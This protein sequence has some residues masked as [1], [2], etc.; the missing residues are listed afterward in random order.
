MEQQTA[1][2][3]CSCQ[4]RTLLLIIAKIELANSILSNWSRSHVCHSLQCWA[5]AQM[6]QQTADAKVGLLGQLYNTLVFSNEIIDH[7]KDWISQFNIRSN[8]T[9]SLV[10]TWLRNH[11]NRATDCFQS[12]ISYTLHCLLKW[13]IIDHCIDWISQFN[14]VY[15]PFMETEREYTSFY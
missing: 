5:T 4:P 7:C 14:I 8:E 11:T 9:R 1:R 2:A 13:K 15:G 6:E 3:A 10:T 12:Q